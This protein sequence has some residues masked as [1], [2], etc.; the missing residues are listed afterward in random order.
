MKANQSVITAGKAKVFQG[1]FFNKGT[2]GRWIDLLTQSDIE[3][4]ERKAV[5][6]LGPECAA[7][8]ATGKMPK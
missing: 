3:A 6:E 8:L 4:Y 2:N 1:Q 7:W 5:E